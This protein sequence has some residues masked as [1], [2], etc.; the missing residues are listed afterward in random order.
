MEAQLG[1]RW[2][3]QDRMASW[4]RSNR[5]GSI[6]VSLA[7]IL[8]LAAIAGA[9][10]ALLAVDS[11]DVE[12]LQATVE[13]VAAESRAVTN[14]FLDEAELAGGVVARVLD[15]DPSSSNEELRRV[16]QLLVAAHDGIDGIFVGYADGAF[17]YVTN[18]LATE[19]GG[20]RMTLITNADLTNREVRELQLDS[21]L[22]VVSEELVPTDDYD[23]RDRP[24]YL[25]AA[26]DESGWTDPY[27]F[28]SSLEPGITHYRRHDSFSELGTVLG[29]DMRLAEVTAFLSERQPGERGTAAIVSPGGMVVAGSNTLPQEDINVDVSGDLPRG[30]IIASVL[31]IDDGQDRQVTARTA[32]GQEGDWTL[33]VSA[34]ASDF[35]DRLTGQ[36]GNIRTAIPLAALG[37]IALVAVLTSGA[38]SR[39]KRLGRMAIVDAET[40]LASRAEAHACLELLLQGDD[41]VIALTVALG[42]RE[43]G[44]NFDVDNSV[45][46]QMGAVMQEFATRG[47]VAGRIGTREFLVARHLAQGERAAGLVTDLYRRLVGSGNRDDSLPLRDDTPVIGWEVIDAS[48]STPTIDGVLRNLDL[49]LLTAE[50]GSRPV[51]EYSYEL[52]PAIVTDERL[53][54]ELTGA[55]DSGEFLT[56]F[57]PEIDLRTGEVVGAEALL[58]RRLSDGDLQCAT[59]FIADLERLGLLSSLTHSVLDETIDFAMRWSA[60]P[61]FTIRINL[62]ASELNNPSVASRLGGLT[63][64]TAHHWC[65][66]LTERTIESLSEATVERLQDL[67]RSGVGIALD[68]FGTGY[69]S[70]AELKRLPITTLKIDRT[71]V[72]PLTAAH[73]ASVSIAALI[74]NVAARLGLDLV[75]EG[76]ETELQ[77]QALVD[78]GCE[79]GQGW[80]MA[81][82]LPANEFAIWTSERQG[83]SDPLLTMPTDGG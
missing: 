16:M 41:P 27:T 24:W 4:K 45:L 40:G 35:S 74:Q 25:A 37:L 11:S 5:V 28:A 47:G 67:A 54:R 58:R 1:R 79:R 65:I 42:H 20:L 7:A 60:L 77:R 57:Q 34:T 46:L 18:G 73:G 52:Q 68:D 80:L 71:F 62:S 32:V 26:Q 21:D 61:S 72:E 55:I 19:P 22:N 33:V 56:Y 14:E 29:V 75:A 38:L 44:D 36:V 15:D 82:A 39:I 63:D 59:P 48:G 2:F 12:P 23:P 83:G 9:G 70:M 66:E 43:F 13:A 50:A 76:V 53:R 8:V 6:V 49:A 51:V 64:L 81:P 3:G 30:E 31:P 78:L 17:V 69:S 10:V